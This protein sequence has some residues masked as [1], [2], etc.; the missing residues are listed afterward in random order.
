MGIGTYSAGKF[1]LYLAFCSVSSKKQAACR[2]KLT[3]ASGLLYQATNQQM[4][5]RII[6]ELKCASQQ[7][8]IYIKDGSNECCSTLC[9]ITKV[10]YMTLYTDK[11]LDP[12]Q[13]ARVILHEFGHYA[14]CLYDEYMDALRRQPA[15]C[16]DP[17]TYHHCIMEFTER[18]DVCDFCTAITHNTNTTSPLINWQTSENKQSCWDTLSK[19][20]CLG[21]NIPTNLSYA[22]MPLCQSHPEYVFNNPH[23]IFLEPREGGPLRYDYADPLIIEVP[24]ESRFALLLDR[25]GSMT[26]AAMD[27]I[28]FGA[29]FWATY[30]F[31]SD[32][33]LAIIF[34]N[35]EQQVISPLD[36]LSDHQL[37]YILEA[38]TTITPEGQTNLAGALETGLKQL[39]APGYPAST[40]ELIL[41]TD[42]V[43]NTGTLPAEWPSDLVN[44]LAVEGIRLQALG[45]GAYDDQAFLQR[46]TAGARGRFC[47]LGEDPQ[48]SEA[49]LAIQEAFIHLAG[50]LRDG[51]G[52]VLMERDRF[53]E[54]SPAGSKLVATVKRLGNYTPD[55]IDLVRRDL[56]DL[57]HPDIVCRYQVYLEEGS[58]QAAFMVSYLKND[59]VNV[60]LFRPGGEPVMPA[61]DAGVEFRQPHDAPYAFYV[62]NAPAPGDWTLLVV[63]RQAEGEIP[64]SVM[65]CS[66]NPELAVTVDVNRQLF[67][68][69]REITIKALAFYQHLP[70]TDLENPVAL[71]GKG[72]VYSGRPEYEEIILQPQMTSFDAEGKPLEKR[73]PMPDGIYRGVV[74]RSRPGSY[75]V[76]V[77]FHYA[78]KQA[79]RFLRQKDL[80]IHVG[81]LSPGEDIEGG[82]IKDKV[83]TTGGIGLKATVKPPHFRPQ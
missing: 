77:Q 17:D 32:A 44:R 63:R 14:L 69:D 59:A 41:L 35:Q 74:R 33:K 27:G 56:L 60:Y 28:R 67:E 2:V 15:H 75:S 43:H 24:L 30:L 79:P 76:K 31:Q 51:F 25:S 10:G 4:Q 5:F 62:I 47:Q 72:D 39:T 16:A 23:P 6:K 19:N 20:Y 55:A 66:E 26:P 42:G 34:Y 3:E 1:E 18:L 7:A 80:Q 49:Q 29:H 83:A 11:I 65:A 73:V 48:E 78:G 82:G 13:G 57:K 40:Q 9:G 58:R 36:I 22:D 64:F 61:G 45:L 12:N 52:P 68:P 46:V 54:P 38:L 53:Q 8:D 21:Y 37:G 50:E 70:L 71:V 81:P